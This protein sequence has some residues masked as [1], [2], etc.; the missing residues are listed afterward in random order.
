MHRTWKQQWQRAAFSHNVLSLI[1]HFCYCFSRL[2]W[3]ITFVIVFVVRLLSWTCRWSWCWRGR[4][5]D[6][7]TRRGWG[8]RTEER[9]TTDEFW[10]PSPSAKKSRKNVILAKED[11]RRFV[12]TNVSVNELCEMTFSEEVI[13]EYV[14]MVKSSTDTLKKKCDNGLT[15]GWN[16]KCILPCVSGI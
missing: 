15:W 12:G 8:R 14:W 2:C 3:L 5:G 10:R 7:A 13:G 6:V 9:G 4:S 16:S 1:D 11:N